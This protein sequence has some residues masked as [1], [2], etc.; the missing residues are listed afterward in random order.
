MLSLD[1][2]HYLS[3]INAMLPVLAI[4]LGIGL[5]GCFSDT[6]A[7]K[8]EGK[9]RLGAYS[10]GEAA[11]VWIAKEKQ[12]FEQVGLDVEV[13]PFSAGKL[14]ADAL[15]KG[16]VDMVTCADFVFVKR[17]F[18]EKDLRIL[19]AIAAS[20]TLWMTAHR[21]KGILVPGDLKGKRI[22]VTMDSSGEYFLGRFLASHALELHDVNTVDLTPPKIVASMLDQSI[23]AAF[24]WNPNIYHIQKKLNDSVISFEG[25]GGQNLYFVLLTK[26]GWL[27]AHHEHSERLI[28]A[29]ELAEKWIGNHTEEATQLLSELFQVDRSYLDATWEPQRVRIFFPQALLVAMNGEK[30]WLVRRRLVDSDISPNLSEFLSLDPMEKVKPHAVTVIK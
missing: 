11:L 19:G 16:D 22:G 27:Q 3:R 13:V 2:P 10:G 15:S 24:T 14:A 18:L 28:Q 29:L 12:Y 21:D 20:K 9:I 26:D 1:S 23:D 17:S 5:N 7:P 25:Q 4:L 8:L 6:P 30:R